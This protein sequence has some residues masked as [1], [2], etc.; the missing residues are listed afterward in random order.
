M[1]IDEEFKKARTP[2]AKDVRK[3][4]RRVVHQWNKIEGSLQK[5]TDLRDIQRWV[6]NM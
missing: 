6:P 3:R 2:G 5:I 4:K 1:S